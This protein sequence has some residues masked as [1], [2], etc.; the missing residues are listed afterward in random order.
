MVQYGMVLYSTDSDIF[1]LLLREACV[2]VPH[3]V[4]R[5]CFWQ[6]DRLHAP[7]LLVLFYRKLCGTCRL[8]VDIFLVRRKNMCL[9]VLGRCSTTEV[10]V[11]G[12]FRPCLVGLLVLTFG[13]KSQKPNQRGCFWRVLFFRSNCFSV[14]HFWKLGWP[15]F[16]LLTFC[17]SKLV[18]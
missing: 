5:C 3:I 14:V 17:F 16:W 15:C 8:F 12:M 13:P 11:K 7:W 18:E 4:E 1:M 10:T 2:T 9:I 6:S